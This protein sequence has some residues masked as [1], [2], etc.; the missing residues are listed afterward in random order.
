MS[1]AAGPSSE[2]GTRCTTW[3]TNF[4]NNSNT[5]V[6]T[7]VIVPPGGDYFTVL[8]DSSGK[9][10]PNDVVAPANAVS[11]RLDLAPGAIAVR[12]YKVCASTPPPY[13][14]SLWQAQLPDSV[15]VNWVGGY[16]GQACW[17]V[18]H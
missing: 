12:S 11:I 3:T 8:Y 18:C 14:T 5:S 4:H 10:V 15:V 1:G 6:A 9:Q 2:P 16:Q 7:V 13:T 17:R